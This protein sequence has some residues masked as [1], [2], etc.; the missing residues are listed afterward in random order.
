MQNSQR[1][2]AMAPQATTL[3]HLDAL[4]TSPWIFAR[5]KKYTMGAPLSLPREAHPLLSPPS[6]PGEGWFIWLHVYLTKARAP[7]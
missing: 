7:C 4:C 6:N 5:D 2:F 3:F 1:T